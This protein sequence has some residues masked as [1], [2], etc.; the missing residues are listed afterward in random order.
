MS[1]NQSTGNSITCI[2]KN[3]ITT[4][5]FAYFNGDIEIPGK[6]INEIFNRTK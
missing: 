1:I 2:R 6:T 3:Y 5:I 4:K